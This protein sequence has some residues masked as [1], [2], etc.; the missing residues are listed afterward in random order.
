M[1]QLL[2]HPDS[3]VLK[4]ILHLGDIR[5]IS[6]C[7][8]FRNKRPL[9][10]FDYDQTANGWECCFLHK[11]LNVADNNYCCNQDTRITK[12]NPR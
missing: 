8:R 9:I 4:S 1:L 12:A 2:P 10:S 3:V 7:L 6:A 5:L 11:P